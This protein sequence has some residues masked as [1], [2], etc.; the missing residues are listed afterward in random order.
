MKLGSFLVQCLM[1]SEEGMRNSLG[2]MLGLV[3]SKG[4][5]KNEKGLTVMEYA[6]AAAALISVAYYAMQNLGVS[7]SDNLSDTSDFLAGSHIAST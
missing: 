7:L 6:V 3:R 2:K 5:N 1:N 4:I